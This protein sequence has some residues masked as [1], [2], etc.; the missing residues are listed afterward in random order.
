M[1]VDNVAYRRGMG[2]DLSEG[3]LQAN[4]KRTSLIPEGDHTST[5]AGDALVG[6]R[7]Q[8]LAAVGMARLQAEFGCADPETER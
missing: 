6:R 7:R 3:G 1:A 2:V 5:P 8:Q 4:H